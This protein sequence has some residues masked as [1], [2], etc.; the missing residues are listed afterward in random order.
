[1][2]MSL[3]FLHFSKIVLLDTELLVARIF[4]I[5]FNHFNMLSPCILASMVSDEKLLLNLLRIHHTRG[6]LSLSW[7]FQESFFDFQQFDYVSVDLFVFLLVRVGR[8]FWM[9]RFN[10]KLVICCCCFVFSHCFFKYSLCFC[11]GL[12]YYVYWCTWGY[13]T[14]ILGSVLVPSFLSPL[15]T[16]LDKFKW[17]ILKFSESFACSNA[18]WTPLVNFTFQI[19]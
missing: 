9:Y 1:M 3:F 11:S 7:C 16:R 6:A 19:L 2:G 10:T 12:S 18:C 8:A 5:P 17:H 14:R 13:F 15:F 4:F